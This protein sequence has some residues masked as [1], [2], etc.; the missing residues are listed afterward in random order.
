M[1]ACTCILIT[2]CR[3]MMDHIIVIDVITM[4]I[5]GVA[6]RIEGQSVQVNSL[7]FFHDVFPFVC[8]IQRVE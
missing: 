6:I 8:Y 4:V 2:L 5:V 1:Y 3:I 7:Y